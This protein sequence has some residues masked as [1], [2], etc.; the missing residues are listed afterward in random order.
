MICINCFEPSTNVINSR[1]HKK[2]AS[3]WR[4]RRCRACRAIFT[5]TEAPVVGDALQIIYADGSTESFSLPRLT[6]NFAGVLAHHSEKAADESYWLA[7]TVYQLLIER[8]NSGQAIPL[9][10]FVTTAHKVLERFDALAG[11]QYAAKHR[12]V[13][14]TRKSPGRPRFR[15]N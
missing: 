11:L 14:N 8:G 12:L 3:V 7:E 5:T 13:T 1:P 4:R 6:V 9:H 15:T 2:Q 10:E